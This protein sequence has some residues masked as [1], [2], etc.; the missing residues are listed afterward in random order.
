MS[1]GN[2]SIPT[3]PS[4]SASNQ[5]SSAV[6]SPSAPHSSANKTS[7]EMRPPSNSYKPSPNQQLSIGYGNP[8]NHNS[9]RNFV[10]SLASMGPRVAVP[11]MTS[12]GSASPRTSHTNMGPPSVVRPGNGMGP[13]SLARSGNNMAAPPNYRATSSNTPATHLLPPAVP[14]LQRPP[15]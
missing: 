10:T 13:P 11:T 3:S 8:S 2:T 1:R 6:L 5:T 4:N 9:S 12:T 7:S 14:K 15:T